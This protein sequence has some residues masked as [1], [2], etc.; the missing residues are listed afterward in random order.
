M[1]IKMRTK[2]IDTYEAGRVTLKAE[3]VYPTSLMFKECTRC[4]L[5]YLLNDSTQA[6]VSRKTKISALL[7]RLN[8]DIISAE[9]KELLMKLVS[10]GKDDMSVDYGMSVEELYKIKKILKGLI[11]TYMGEHL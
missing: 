11:M 4:V 6:E 2:A 3:Q 8:D 7:E 5:T 1:K 10:V 9:D